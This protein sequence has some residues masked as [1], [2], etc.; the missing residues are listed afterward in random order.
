MSNLRHRWGT[1]AKTYRLEKTPS[2]IGAVCTSTRIAFPLIPWQIKVSIAKG[3]GLDLAVAARQ[4]ESHKNP[5][6]LHPLMV[7]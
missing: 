3:G 4:V 1:N 5:D 6:L 7:A 2:S